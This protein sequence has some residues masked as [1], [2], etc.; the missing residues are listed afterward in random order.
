ME[1]KLVKTKEELHE[2][3]KLTYQEFLKKGYIDENEDKEFIHF[4]GILDNIPQTSVFIALE[5]NKVVGTNSITMD[6]ENGIHTMVDFPKTTMRERLT[7]KVLA[8]SWRIVVDHNYKHTL[9]IK[10]L[11]KATIDLGLSKGTE[12]CLFTFNPKHAF[13]YQKLLNAEIVEFTESTIGFHNA[14]A[15][16]MR[17]DTKNIPSWWFK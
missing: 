17:L 13:I 12:T 4:H 1:I 9:V 11:I 8:S 6:S 15:V 5:D 7:G 2:V 10:K 3:Y 14:P 16:L